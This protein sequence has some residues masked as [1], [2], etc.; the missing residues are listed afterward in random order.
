[1][2]FLENVPESFLE[3][4]ASIATKVSKPKNY[5]IRRSVI[6]CSDKRAEYLT[7]ALSQIFWGLSSSQIQQ[8]GVKG[9]ITKLY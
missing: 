5:H 1:M 3:V 8:I 9:Y 4:D 2:S 6:Q 7:S